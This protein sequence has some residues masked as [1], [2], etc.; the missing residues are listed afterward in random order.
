MTAG[1]LLLIGTES[2]AAFEELESQVTLSSDKNVNFDAFFFVEERNVH[3]VTL[4]S[5]SEAVVNFE[6]NVGQGY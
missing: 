4:D 2:Y 6:V 5:A 1:N 3:S